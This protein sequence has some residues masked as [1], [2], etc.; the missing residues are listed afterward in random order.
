[1]FLTVNAFFSIFFSLSIPEAHATYNTKGLKPLK[2]CNSTGLI[3]NKVPDVQVIKLFTC[4][5]VYL[6]F[7]PFFQ[8]V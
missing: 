8:H 5:I 1:M 3:K 7:R 6:L 2:V 4:V